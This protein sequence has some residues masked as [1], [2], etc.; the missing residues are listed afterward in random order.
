MH[1]VKWVWFS[2]FEGFYKLTLIGMT[3]SKGVLDNSLEPLTDLHLC[4]FGWLFSIN[5]NHQSILFIN[6]LV[7]IDF[8]RIYMVYM[9]DALSF[10]SGAVI[11]TVIS[12]W[13]TFH[14]NSL[15]KQGFKYRFL[16]KVLCSTYEKHKLLFSKYSKLVKAK[17]D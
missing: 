5:V 3:Y 1:T 10:L 17:T 11:I 12:L 7:Y 2:N 15:L 4:F 6:A 13:G 14:F 16:C 8:H 9:F